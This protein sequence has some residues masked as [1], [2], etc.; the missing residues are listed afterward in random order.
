MARAGSR[1]R[2]HSATR[3]E[4]NQTGTFC[5]IITSVKPVSPA[6]P[7]P[8]FHRLCSDA[9]AGIDF[10]GRLL[11]YKP[12]ARMTPAQALQHEWLAGQASKQRTRMIERELS[13]A[14]RVMENHP[15]P[16]SAHTSHTSATPTA[17]STSATL[18]TTARTTIPSAVNGR[19][20]KAGN[21]LS[22]GRSLSSMS[23][24]DKHEDD[25]AAQRG[26]KRVR[27]ATSA[28]QVVDKAHYSYNAWT[29]INLDADEIPGLG[30]WQMMS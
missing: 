23:V 21:M 26:V 4:V 1:A 20:R 3:L 5:G 6:L 19:K 11:E 16:A 13:L 17:T 28:A 27:I 25:G 8:P 12:D 2:P 18:P 9:R 29:P 22:L 15:I 14:R 7:D 30:M 10:I 24:E